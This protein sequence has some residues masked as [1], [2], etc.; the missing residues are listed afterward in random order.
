[1]HL[2]R[3]AALVALLAAACAANAQYNNTWASLDSR[4][5]P[6]WYDQAKFGIFVHWCVPAAAGRSRSLARARA[7]GR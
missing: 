6:G 5:L 3:V 2:A 7:R 1:M 4:P